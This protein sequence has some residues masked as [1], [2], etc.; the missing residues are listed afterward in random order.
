MTHLRKTKKKTSYHR[1]KQPQLQ[2]AYT[3]LIFATS[4]SLNQKRRHYQKVKIK[5]DL[6]STL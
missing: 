3:K 1:T 4:L 5:P 6:H 2:D